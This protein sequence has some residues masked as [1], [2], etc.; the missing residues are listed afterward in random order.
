MKNQDSAWP[1]GRGIPSLAITLSSCGRLLAAYQ[2]AKPNLSPVRKH[3]YRTWKATLDTLDA[4]RDPRDLPL[5][6]EALVVWRKL[7]RFMPA[8]ARV[9]DNDNEGKESRLGVLERCAWKECECHVHRPLHRV[10]LCKGCWLV[11]YCGA[12]CQK[13]DWREGGHHEVCRGRGRQRPQT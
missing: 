6:R 11:A 9:D 2:P 4:R 8:D 1:V 5:W 12:R 13:S 10:K 7:G 3:T